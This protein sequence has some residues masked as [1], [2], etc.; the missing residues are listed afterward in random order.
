[1]KKIIK[2]GVVLSITMCALL[3][4]GCSAGKAVVND[5]FND[6]ASHNSREA[7]LYDFATEL[8]EQQLDVPSTA[9]FPTFQF[10][11]VEKV[12]IDDPVYDEC[13]Q[14]KSTVDCEDV[15]GNRSVKSFTVRIGIKNSEGKMYGKVYELN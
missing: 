3:E 9:I 13:Y 8:V 7:D 6:V 4:T 10:S 15:Y 11:Y 5:V 1:M 14:V 12:D 2:I